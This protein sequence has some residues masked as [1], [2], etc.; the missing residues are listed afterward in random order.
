A[1]F[2]RS[3]QWTDILGPIQ[4]HNQQR[5]KEEVTLDSE[6]ILQRLIE[7][8]PRILPWHEFQ[9]SPAENEVRVCVVCE[10]VSSPATDILLIERTPTGTGRFVIVETKLIKNP[11]SHRAVLGQILEYAASLSGGQTLAELEATATNY[12]KNRGE[13]FSG[14]FKDEMKKVFGEDWR[15][16][17]WKTAF[18]GLKKGDVRLL[19]V[20]DRL[21]EDLRL[22][23]VFLP[24]S[25]LLSA[26]EIQPHQQT[27]SGDKLACV[28]SNSAA[29]AGAEDVRRAME[30][31][32][33][34]TLLSYAQVQALVGRYITAEAVGHDAPT[35]PKPTRTY[36]DHLKK[37]GGKETIPGKALELLR[38]EALDTDG[39]V[40]E[41]EVNLTIRMWDLSGLLVYEEDHNLGLD[42]WT[43]EPLRPP[44][45]DEVRGLFLKEFPDYENVLREWTKYGF[46]FHPISA[47]SKLDQVKHLVRRISSLYSKLH[48]LSK[49]K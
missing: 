17:I 26:I 4:S 41:G 1:E 44:R 33:S 47:N 40:H 25:V 23:V 10:G 36:E 24:S 9:D 21:Y 20:S 7:I 42:F 38:K 48:K 30:K 45:K 18:D 31:Y 29:T 19:I 46:F 5:E 49:R 32:F 2:E 11:D 27:A 16:V 34:N 13:R 3:L 12:W 37:L 39:R 15:Q 14:D 8:Y 35:V 22:A 28:V 43:T 6:Y